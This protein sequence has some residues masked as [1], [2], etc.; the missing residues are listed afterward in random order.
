VESPQVSPPVV[1]IYINEAVE[2]VGGQAWR[3]GGSS[4]TF[5]QFQ[6]AGNI[7]ENAKSGYVITNSVSADKTIEGT[8]NLT[9]PNAGHISGGFH[10]QWI[11]QAGPLCG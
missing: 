4:E 7:S 10:A 1:R 8:V 2:Q 9:F 5:A 11:S 6:S 3:V